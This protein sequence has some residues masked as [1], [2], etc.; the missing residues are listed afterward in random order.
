MGRTYG[1]SGG[2][3]SYPWEQGYLR[4]EKGDHREDLWDSERT[5]RVSLYAIHREGADGDESRAYLCMHELEE[6]SEDP[7]Q[8]RERR[9]AVPGSSIYFKEDISQDKREVLEFDSDT[10]LCLQSEATNKT[11][12]VASDCRQSTVFMTVFLI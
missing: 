2:Y 7:C 11:L 8:E 12:F 6:T 1:D 4:P 5:P 10:S 9:T 3:P